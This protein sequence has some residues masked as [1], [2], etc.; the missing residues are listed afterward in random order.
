MSDDN[1]GAI[2]ETLL[3]ADPTADTA[4]VVT[5]TL[6]AIPDDRRSELIGPLLTPMLRDLLQVHPD[7]SED[8]LVAELKRQVRRA[9]YQREGDEARRKE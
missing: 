3:D 2:I 4:T 7:W 1:I 6:A 5:R 9:A 8:V